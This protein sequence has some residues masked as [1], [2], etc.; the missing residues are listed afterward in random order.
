M[1]TI[2]DKAAFTRAVETG[3]CVVVS[4][5]RKSEAATDRRV[6]DVAPSAELRRSFGHDPSRWVGFCRRYKAELAYKAELLGELWAI[7]RNNTLTLV[8]AA[9]DE[10]H[11]EAIIFR[12][13]LTS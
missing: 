9:R 10:L 8:F 5:L 6:N 4:S 13:V 12:D 11:N 7:A 3:L 1:M 2:G